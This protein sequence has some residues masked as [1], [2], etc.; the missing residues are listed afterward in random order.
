MT[1]P[2]TWPLTTPLTQPLSLPL[3]SAFGK[4]KAQPWSSGPFSLLGNAIGSTYNHTSICRL[5]PNGRLWALAGQSATLTCYDVSSGTPI[6]LAEISDSSV[7]AGLSDVMFSAD[8]HWAW[9]CAETSA[10]I[11]L[12]DISTAASGTIS[13]ITSLADATGLAGATRL[14][15]NPAGTHACCSTNGRRGLYIVALNNPALGQ[16]PTLVIEYRGATP[17]TTFRGMRCNIWVDAT[18]I[19]YCCENTAVNTWCV[20]QVSVDL[21]TP[22]VTDVWHKDPSIDANYKAAKGVILNTTDNLLYWQVGTGSGTHGA[23]VISDTS[24]NTQGQYAPAGGTNSSP[25]SLFNARCGVR[26]NWNSRK[27]L[28]TNAEVPCNLMIVEVTTAASPNDVAHTQG[29]VPLTT[30]NGSMWL[31]VIATA[32][33]N[34][35]NVWVACFSED[36]NPNQGIQGVK[37]DFSKLS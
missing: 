15:M 6:K 34:V 11:T 36:G 3:G 23:T 35:F 26:V 1:L 33:P 16:A 9:T 19:Y 27:F 2:I 4:G 10:A 17:N 32:D 29:P 8:G 18:T 21:V 25:G 5:D 22:A 12:W 14:S 31:V 28:I 20:G 7:M 37:L 24:G 30:L 13:K